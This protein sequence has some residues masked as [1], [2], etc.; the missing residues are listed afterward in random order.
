MCVTGGRDTQTNGI[1]QRTQKQASTNM[2][3]SFD[4]NTKTI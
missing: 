4:K 1:E 3:N 2:A